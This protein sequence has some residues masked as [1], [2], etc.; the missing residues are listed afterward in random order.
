LQPNDDD[1]TTVISTDSPREREQSLPT[2]QY[3]R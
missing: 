1:D 2:Q 3:H